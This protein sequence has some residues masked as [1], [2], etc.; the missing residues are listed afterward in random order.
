MIRPPDAAMLRKLV[1]ARLYAIEESKRMNRGMLVVESADQLN[2]ELTSYR[3]WANFF[4][5]WR[6]I[7]AYHPREAEL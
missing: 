4:P 7:F 5:R 2:P 1:A 3:V 6:I